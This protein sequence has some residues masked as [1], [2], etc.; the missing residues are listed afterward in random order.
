[1]KAKDFFAKIGE[2]LKTEGFAE[3]IDKVPD[4]DFDDQFLVDFE[5]TYLTRERA[6]ADKEVNGKLRAQILN[7]IDREI[8]EILKAMAYP[9]M[10]DV[11][12]E[13]DTYKKIA[14][15]TKQI[16]EFGKA[17]SKGVENADEFK[18]KLKEYEDREQDYLKR[19]STIDDDH[20]KELQ[21]RD[22]KHQ[23]DFHDYRLTSELEK[24]SN[25]YIFAEAYE[26]TRPALTNAIL[27]DLKKSNLL[28]LAMK[29]NGETDIQVLE[30][31]ENP[32]PKF[33]GNTPVT[34]KNLLDEAYKPFLKQ[35]NTDNNGQGQTTQQQSTT[36]VQNPSIRQGHRTTVE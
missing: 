36:T 35:S 26:K 14:L 31:G 34:V 23:K 12:K 13:Q 2:H 16:P 10:H 32:R 4:F 22:E 25:K 21:L 9:N 8:K 28:Q 7:P 15:V 18:K 1:M 29:E 27:G 24:L 33:N 3:F 17:S 20:K 30:P 19:F 6:A 5:N 11:D